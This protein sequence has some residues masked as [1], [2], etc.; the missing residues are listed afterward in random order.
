MEDVPP[1]IPV[2]W[3]P[4]GAHG[5]LAC[6]SLCG[7]ARRGNGCW[8]SG[9]RKGRLQLN[10]GLL[11]GVL[12][13]YAR[14]HDFCT[15]EWMRAG[16][17]SLVGALTPDWGE[18]VCDRLGEGA[19]QGALLVGVVGVDFGYGQPGELRAPNEQLQARCRLS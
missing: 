11:C 15:V 19:E 3:R 7:Y 2:S 6:A 10:D 8:P 18:D 12:H 1:T 4:E 17:G 16:G 9:T 13:A 5:T 14:E